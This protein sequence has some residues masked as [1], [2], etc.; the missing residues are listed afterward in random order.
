MSFFEMLVSFIGLFPYV[1]VSFHIKLHDLDDQAV[2]VHDSTQVYGSLSL[3]TSLLQI[4]FLCH[5]SF[6][7]LQK[8]PVHTKRGSAVVPGANYIFMLFC[9]ILFFSYVQRGL[10]VCIHVSLRIYVIP[11]ACFHLVDGVVSVTTCTL[12][13]YPHTTRNSY[14]TRIYTRRNSYTFVSIHDRIGM[15]TSMLTEQVCIYIYIYTYI[16]MLYITYQT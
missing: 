15:L 1:Q 4:S 12:G 13:G 9:M 14:T 16:Y 2:D 5:W 8:R 7:Q 11:G 10:F 6:L 3:F